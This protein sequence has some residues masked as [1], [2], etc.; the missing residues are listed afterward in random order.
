MATPMQALERLDRI[1][2]QEAEAAEAELKAALSREAYE[3]TLERTAWGEIQA[4]VT[5]LR[6]IQTHLRI[7]ET[8]KDA[9]GRSMNGTEARANLNSAVLL[10]N[11]TVGAL[12]R[13]EANIKTAIGMDVQKTKVAV[14]AAT[15]LRTAHSQLMIEHSRIK[16][17]K[18]W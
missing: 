1:I 9:G 8:E 11:A 13:A 12:T 3:M 7:A 17:E 16:T 18:G 14:D 15:K 5:N 10:L 2:I 4:I 6:T